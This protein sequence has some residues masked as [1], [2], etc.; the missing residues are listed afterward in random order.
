MHDI[1]GEISVL[2]VY[3]YVHDAATFIGFFAAYITPFL[4]FLAPYLF[5]RSYFTEHQIFATGN[6]R[7]L[8]RFLNYYLRAMGRLFYEVA[9]RFDT[10][11]AASLA[12]LEVDWSVLQLRHNQLREKKKAEARRFKY[13]HYKK[14]YKPHDPDP[15]V[16]KVPRSSSPAYPDHPFTS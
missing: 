6:V 14:V 8:R 12:E 10:K 2:Y 16:D 1:F 3:A 7:V 15:S 11:A 4:C 13:V 5:Y 9:P